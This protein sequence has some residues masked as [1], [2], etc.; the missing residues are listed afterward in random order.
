MIDKYEEYLKNILKNTKIMMI[1][2][3]CFVDDSS[4]DEETAIRFAKWI[5][6]NKARHF[7]ES[8]VKDALNM[9]SGEM[10]EEVDKLLTEARAE[11]NSCVKKVFKAYRTIEPI[12]AALLV[13][14]QNDQ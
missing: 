10:K 14:E 1:L 11:L 6:T 4:V 2:L 3:E 9:I 5:T 7:P 12:I 13:G 8:K